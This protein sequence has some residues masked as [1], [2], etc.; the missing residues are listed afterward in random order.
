MHGSSF[1]G[2]GRAGLLAIKPADLIFVE[3]TKCIKNREVGFHFADAVGVTMANCE[4]HENLLGGVAFFGESTGIKL[5]ENNITKNGKTGLVLEKGSKLEM[6]RGNEASEN[7]GKQFWQDAVF[8]KP[9]TA[10]L[11]PAPDLN[12]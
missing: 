11:P 12:E 2:N 7:E 1:E 8:E 10:D 3:D 9:E 6:S 4:S 5:T